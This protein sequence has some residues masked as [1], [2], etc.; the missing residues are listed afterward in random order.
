MMGNRFADV[1]PSWCNKYSAFVCFNGEL[2]KL[3]HWNKSNSVKIL[4]GL[5]QHSFVIED[6]SGGIVAE[7]IYG[8]QRI[9]GFRQIAI[10]V[11]KA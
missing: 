2:S 3:E 10:V 7:G 8:K 1:A 9:V 11:A 4:V 6:S 5:G